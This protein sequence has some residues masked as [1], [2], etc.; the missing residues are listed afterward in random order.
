MLA[1]CGGGGSTTEVPVSKTTIVRGIVRDSSN[2]PMVGVTVTSGAV[3]VLTDNK[4]EYTLSVA[5]GSNIKISANKTGFVDVIDFCGLGYGESAEVDFSL[6]AVDYEKTL[7]LMDT[8]LT[9]AKDPAH[10]TE[11]KLPAGSIVD[12]TGTPVTTAKVEVAT[13]MP[14]DLNYVE[15][16][17]GLFIGSQTGQPDKPIESFGFISVEITDATGNIKYNLGKDNSGNAIEADI[18]IPVG[19]GTAD[20][21]TLT[22]ELWSLDES[23]GKWIYEGLANRDDSVP[24]NVVYR[25]KVKHFST[26]NLDRPIQTP[27]SL[28]VTVK[29]GTSVVAGASVVAK[30]TIAP[31]WEGRGITGPDGTF[32]FDSVPVGTNSIKATFGDLGGT[33][34]S[35]SI[36]GTN[37]T[38]T[39]TLVQQVAKEIYFFYT[40]GGVAKPAKGINV[41][42]MSQGTGPGGGE[43]FGVTDD[44]GKYIFSLTT[45]LPFYSLQ[46]STTVGGTAYSF[47][48]MYNLISDIPAEVELK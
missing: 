40:E 13:S 20:P 14:T 4:G 43:S 37:G 17:P 5:P 15:N 46:A 33:V 19:I 16:F 21:G 48:K 34:Y 38:A 10:G 31:A 22:I 11:I 30:K 36:E 41:G 6:K 44:N 9:I 23:T 42:I 32:K 26:Y 47:Y 8:T 39:I 45:G 25:G 12:S 3:S 7:T 28:T 2:N 18:A 35:Y 29:N 24:A 27:I 1:G